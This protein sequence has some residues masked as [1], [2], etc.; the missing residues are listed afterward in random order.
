VTVTVHVPHHDRF[1]AQVAR[2]D[3][4]SRV[5]FPK[6]GLE[7]HRT[8]GA[9][10]K[11]LVRALGESLISPGIEDQDGH[12]LSPTSSGVR[13]DGILRATVARR[14][15]TGMPS[16]ARVVSAHGSIVMAFSG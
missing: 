2:P 3:D 14:H 6:G 12:G 4:G 15:H 5:D 13:D 7:L 8:G 1:A 16:S 9:A 10:S 11:R